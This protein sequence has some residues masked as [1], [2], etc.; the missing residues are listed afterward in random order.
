MILEA[1]RGT[2]PDG[3]YLTDSWLDFVNTGT[4]KYIRMF[5]FT[6]L[7]STTGYALYTAGLSR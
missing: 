7:I 3:R 2:A 6:I 5:L 4:L 1:A